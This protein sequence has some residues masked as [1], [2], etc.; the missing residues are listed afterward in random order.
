VVVGVLTQAMAQL[1]QGSVPSWARAV[2]IDE[3][4]GP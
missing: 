1:D 2:R 4:T 3:A